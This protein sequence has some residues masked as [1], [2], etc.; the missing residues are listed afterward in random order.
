MRVKLFIRYLLNRNYYVIYINT[1]SREQKAQ[2]ALHQ[3]HKTAPTS[4]GW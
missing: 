2:S 4:M 3:D 1:N